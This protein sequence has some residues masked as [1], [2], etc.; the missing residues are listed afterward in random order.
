MVGEGESPASAEENEKEAL[1]AE[2]KGYG[3]EATSR[4][5]V[6]TLREKLE[7]AKAKQGQ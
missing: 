5:K 2:L 6:E 4:S 3:I 1:I 7:E